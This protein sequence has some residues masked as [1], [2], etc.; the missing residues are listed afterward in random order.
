MP[1]NSAILFDILS[2][3][4][5]ISSLYAQRPIVH[6]QANAA[7]YHPFVEAFALTFVDAP[8]TFVRLIVFSIVLYFLVGLQQTASQFLYETYS[9]WRIENSLYSIVQHF[10]PVRVHDIVLHEGA[11]SCNLRDHETGIACSRALR[12]DYSSYGALYWLYSPKNF[13]D[14]GPEVVYAYKCL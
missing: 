2:S 1:S 6:R 12:C 7:M 5:E 8:V 11:L 13:N 14:W 9:I 10:L 3:M 4:G